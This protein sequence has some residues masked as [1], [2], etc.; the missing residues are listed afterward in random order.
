LS[1]AEKESEPMHPAEI[2]P[3]VKCDPLELMCK[4]ASIEKHGNRAILLSYLNEDDPIVCTI[5]EF[6]SAWFGDERAIELW[7]CTRALEEFFASIEQNKD[8]L[9]KDV[10]LKT[11]RLYK[12]SG[13]R[14]IQGLNEYN[15]DVSAVDGS[16]YLRQR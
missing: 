11:K 12:S 8:L 5:K 1:E 15:K 16:K 10:V 2:V 6:A 3:T 14:P 4:I 9:L 7:H 13:V